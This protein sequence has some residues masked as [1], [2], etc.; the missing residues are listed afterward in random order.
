MIVD[1]RPDHLKIDRYIVN[2][3]AGDPVRAA[4]I[5]SIVNLADSI[6]A[7]AIAEG[8]EHDDDLEVVTSL[9]LRIVQGWLFA[10]AMPPDELSQ[11][12]YLESNPLNNE[13]VN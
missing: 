2:G 13:G 3:C 8:I 10:P 6:G 12:A 1:C 4:V 5:G 9:G 7:S 11:T